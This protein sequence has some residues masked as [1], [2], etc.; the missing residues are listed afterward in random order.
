MLGK[1]APADLATLGLAAK[2][3]GRDLLDHGLTLKLG[4]SPQVVWIAYR[5]M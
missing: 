2:L 4:K 1:V 3:S 5:K